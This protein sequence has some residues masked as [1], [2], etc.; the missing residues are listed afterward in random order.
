MKA[1]AASNKAFPKNAP[2]PLVQ[3]FVEIPF[4]THLRGGHLGWLSGPSVAEH[5][6]EQR[7]EFCGP[8]CSIEQSEIPCNPFT[9][10]FSHEP[11]QVGEGDPSRV[12]ACKEW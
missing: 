10:A 6:A 1:T 11:I 3:P 12:G 2:F 4:P 9:T 8:Q 7:V 5:L